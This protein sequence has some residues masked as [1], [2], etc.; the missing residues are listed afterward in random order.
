MPTMPVTDLPDPTTGSD[1]PVDVD[2]DTRAS[3]LAILDRWAQPPADMLAKLPKPKQRGADKGRCN[4][5]AVQAR[6]TDYACGGWHGLP[7]VHLDYMGHADVT[8]AL[9]REDPAW[10]WRPAA[11]NPATGGPAYG[12]NAKGLIVMWGHLTLHG[13]ERMCVGTCEPDKFEIEKE[14]IGDMLRNGAMRFGIAVRLW[15]KADHLDATDDT[16]VPDA[17]PAGPDPNEPLTAGRAAAALR[18]VCGGDRD[19]AR[20]WWDQEPRGDGPFPRHQVDAWVTEA[21][22]WYAERQ[23]ALEAPFTDDAP[24]ADAGDDDPEM[25]AAIDSADPH[26]SADGS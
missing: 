16:P 12:K 22:A 3:L 20:E 1:E 21:T 8:E 24:A 2:P 23:A 10:N 14:L 5:A 19:V 13:V 9:I 7:A 18:A 17:A 15:S 11:I 4:E 6:Q 26:G 25:A